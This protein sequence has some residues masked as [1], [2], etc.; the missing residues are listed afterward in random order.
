MIEA[1]I[2]ATEDVL[3]LAGQM[4]LRR[5]DYELRRFGEDL[6]DFINDLDR[7]PRRDWRAR[8]DD[9]LADQTARGRELVPESR[10]DL[11]AYLELWEQNVFGGPPAPEPPLQAVIT[12]FEQPETIQPEPAGTPEAPSMLAPRKLAGA[13]KSAGWW[14]FGGDTVDFYRKLNDARGCI[15]D[16]E[17]M[18]PAIAGRIEAAKPGVPLEID[19]EL[20]AVEALIWR[21]NDLMESA[22]E[23]WLRENLGQPEFAEL[24]LGPT[25]AS[26]GLPL[27]TDDQQAARAKAQ[28]QKIGLRLKQKIAF[29]DNVIF[30]MQ[31]LE[32]AGTIASFALAGGIVIHAVKQGGKVALVKTVAK[33][34]ASA[35]AGAVIDSATESALTAAGL[36]EE[37]IAQV[38][39]AVEILS[40]VLLLRRAGKLKGRPLEHK[41][42][43][44]ATLQKPKPDKAWKAKISGTAQK[45]GTDGHQFRVYREAIKEAKK[46]DVVS[47]DLNHGYNRSLRLPPKTI[48][49]NRRPDVVSIY[50]DKSVNRI[51]VRSKTDSIA[52]LEERNTELD[53]QIIEHGFKPR[54][55]QV[56]TPTKYSKG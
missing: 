6:L 51:E 48:T 30:A 39:G 49:P 23:I 26:L 56:I 11:L 5:I 4:F 34:A 32:T 10:A 37:Q 40:T 25:P 1:Y 54:P 16:I 7:R 13:N 31:V 8:F 35:V 38:Q 46:P 41:P 14:P 29:L 55:P 50:K 42:V 33:M 9:F 36:E 18:L 20:N 52:I 45:T 28:F 27:F 22:R 12:R 3:R 44:P 2:R 43:A 21:H 47:V 53:P 15:Y 19:D 17:R 24:D